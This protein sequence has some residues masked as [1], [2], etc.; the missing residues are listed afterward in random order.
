[1][2]RRDKVPLALLAAFWA[3]LYLPHLLAG[4]T[5]PA[6]DVAA[7]QLPW[8]TVWREQVLSG[9]PPLW[10]SYS[11][12]GRPLLANPNTMAAYPGTL[13]FL[14]ASPER[15]AAWH[16]ALHHL[17][18]L[19]GCY[20]LARRSGAAP[21]A[22]A[23]A[24]AATGTCGVAWSSVTF[25]NFQASLAWATWALATAVPPP[26]PGRAPVRRAL[27]GG[28][29]L[30]LA[31]LGGEPVTAAFAALAWTV[32]VLATWRPFSLVPLLAMPG[33]A[34]A[35]AAPVLVPLVA[36]FPETVRGTLGPAAGALAADALAPRRFLELLAPNLLGPPLADLAGGFWAA[37][38]FPWQR[39]YPVIFLG[40]APLMLLPFARTTARALRSW[41]VIA[42]V[43]LGGAVVLGIPEVARAARDVPLLGGV[44]YAVKFTVLTV[45]AL[46]PLLAAGWEGMTARW[47]RGARRWVRALA[48]AGLLTVPAAAMPE[49]VLRP[50]LATLYPASRTTLSEI[51]SATL[52]RA[53]LLDWAALLLPP[54]ALAFTG[55]VPVVATAV[56]LGANVV[57]GSGVLLFADGDTWA[58]PPPAMAALPDRPT[59][60]VL[61]TREM[62][63]PV[64][65]RPA[66]E[67]FWDLR[68][69]L[70]P[71]YGTR[72]GAAY[73]LTRGPD[74][75]EPVGQELLAAAAASM[76]PEDHARLAR[77]MG[78]TAV[79]GRSQLPGSAGVRCGDFRASVVDRPSPRVYLARRLVPAEGTLAAA[80][81]LAGEGFRAGEDAVVEGAGGVQQTGGGSAVELP[82]R[83]HRRLFDVTAERAGLLVLQQSFMHAW[84]ATVDGHPARVERVNGAALGVRVPPGRHRIAL[85]LE[86]A[87]YHAGLLGPVLLLLVAILSR[88]V[89]TSR[90]R[91][92]A[93][94]DAVHS[95]LATPP[96]RSP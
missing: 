9:S 36:I 49:S 31:V 85:F 27:L 75:L 11:N 4:D 58:Q 43:G 23:V 47:A 6:R 13:L 68:L 30:G 5:L 55:P 66:L 26:G 83:P 38:S 14:V 42:C 2:A 64:H 73:V 40:I 52:R 15:A 65:R 61:E 46:P 29:L 91:S 69:A 87:P 50:V 45:V 28:T 51:P 59:L 37:P 8:R 95:S 20:W 53:A 90:G 63:P 25:L 62:P 77:A 96:A 33:A 39:Y 67:R 48:V 3:A 71:E 19:L 7:T 10:D 12:G 24:A 35:L 88:T 93:T 81:V 21:A 17:L 56:I 89:G 72:W 92:A 18:L 74:G 84:R 76:S 78:A 79:I 41:W 80:T 32:V 60:A 70:V 16:I 57:G 94:G 86:P 82:G 34:A 1:M 44:R 54:A 22:S